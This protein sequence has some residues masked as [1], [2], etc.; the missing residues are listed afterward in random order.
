MTIRADRHHVLDWV[1]H[2]LC[3]T[4]MQRAF[5]MHMD[6]PLAQLPVAL[7]E[8]EVAHSASAAMVVD[9]RCTGSRIALVRIDQDTLDRTLLIAPTGPNII[10]KMVVEFSGCVAGHR[11]A[12]LQ[13][14]PR[15]LQFFS[16]KERAE[17]LAKN[18]LL[19]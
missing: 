13:T 6:E 18:Q 8:V 14:G 15:E 12:G 9:A 19:K 10:R 16:C 3:P 5:V 2:I 11:V 4:S 17:A 7:P 1:E